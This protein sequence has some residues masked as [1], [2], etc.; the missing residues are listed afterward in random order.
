[1]R[2]GSHQTAAVARVL[3][4]LFGLLALAACA[5]SDRPTLA[6]SIAEGWVQDE[7]RPFS[8]EQEFRRYLRD[9]RRAAHSRR[10]S[11]TIT[12]GRIFA[13]SATELIEGRLE[14]GRIV[15]VRRLDFARARPR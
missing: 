11:D 9:L 10:G 8:D 7:L 1:M 2:G 3:A 4:A 12:G 15:E 6:E 14:G 13:L 5:G